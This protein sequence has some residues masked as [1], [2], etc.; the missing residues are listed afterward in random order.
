MSYKSSGKCEA[1]A[2]IR[3]E[4]DNAIEVLEKA[5]GLVITITEGGP[6]V[7]DPCG[8]AKM[9]IGLR[10]SDRTGVWVKL[11]ADSG[12]IFGGGFLNRGK[13]GGSLLL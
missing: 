5:T 7:A 1:C 2:A 6:S 13:D 10:D 3:T 8:E 9:Y 4:L 11:S 12:K